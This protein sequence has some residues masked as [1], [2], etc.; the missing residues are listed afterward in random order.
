[1]KLRLFIVLICGAILNIGHGQDSLTL[2]DAIQITLK[3]NFDILLSLEDVKLKKLQNTWGEAGRYP[4]VDINLTQG[5]NISDQ[6]QNPTSFIQTLLKSNSI[7]GS[8]NVNWTIFNGFAV[9]TNKEKL[10]QLELQSEGNASLIIENAVQGTVVAYN[11]AVLQLQKIN[12]LKEVLN[13]SREKYLYNQMKKDLG[14]AASVDILQYQSAFLTDSSNLILQELAYTNA[15]RN[16]NIFLGVDAE[17]EWKI[18]SQLLPTIELVQYDALKQKMH[19]NNTNLKN[20]MINIEL[21]QKD[22]NLAKS[23]LYPV[24]SFN[25]GSTFSTNRYAIND[26][27]IPGETS[28]T[29]GATLNYF[30]NFTVGFRVFDGGKVKRAIK[31]LEI[32]EAVNEI[33]TNKLKAD[34]NNQLLNAFNLYSTQLRVFEVN[35]LAFAIAKENFEIAMLKEEF[36]NINSFMLRDIEMAYLRT[37]LTLYESSNNLNQTYA[38]LTRLTGGYIQEATSE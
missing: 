25:A 34:L 6:S 12:L 38:T 2:S 31:A 33:Q 11:N 9:R 20:Q 10:E 35:K 24:V 29:N 8:A 16:L 13:L 17:T 27:P 30:A 4:S 3:Q 19:G 23:S 15:I 22:V 37:G 21:L 7:Q 1:M 32:Q 14:L 28:V 18:E 26:F 5:N 36:G